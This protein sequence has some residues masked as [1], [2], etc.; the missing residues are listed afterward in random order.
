[1]PGSK[2]E[3]PRLDQPFVVGSLDTRT[4]AGVVPVVSAQL[5]WSDRVGGYRVRWGIGR[6]SYTVDPGLYALGAPDDRSPVLV[7]A[8]YKLTFD[9]L[10]R[11]LPGRDVWI[12]VLDTRGINVWCAAGKHTFSTDEVCRRIES[13]ELTFAVSHGTIVLPQLG[14]PG[15]SAPEVRRR[16]RFRAVYGPVRAADL[17]AFLESG[18]RATAEMRRVRFTLRDRLVL[19]PV[20]A[21]NVLGIAAAIVV[22]TAIVAGFGPGIFSLGRSLAAAAPVAALVFATLLSGALVT[23]LLLPWVPGRMFALKGA[24]VGAV[25]AALTLVPLA[26][27]FSPLRLAAWAVFMVAASSFIAMNFTGTSTYTSL[28]GVQKE[29]RASLPWQVGG[30]ALAVLLFLAGGFLR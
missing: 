11:E 28:S 26:P 22:G 12:L 29:M 1:L 2:V 30:T 16:T 6:Y 27:A 5:T 14:A 23:P 19:V 17:P 25:V 13:S 9:A 18:M 10:R 15:V 20:E 4:P 8:N 3:R 7:T 21:V 24:V